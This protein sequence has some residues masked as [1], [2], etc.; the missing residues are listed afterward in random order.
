MTLFLRG[1]A[2]QPVRLAQMGEACDSSISNGI[3]VPIVLTM[4]DLPLS[5]SFVLVPPVQ[6]SLRTQSRHLTFNEAES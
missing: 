6:P 1:F 4:R 2:A 3:I 5:L